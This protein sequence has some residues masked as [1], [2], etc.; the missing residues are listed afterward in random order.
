MTEQELR[1][2]LA[3]SLTDEMPAET[4]M[5]V[6]NKIRERKE[7]I[8][9]SK[10]SVALV[11][12][13]VLTLLSTVAIAYT[14]SREYFED[15]AVLQFESGYYED[16]GLAEKQAMVAILQEHGLISA[17]Q[18]D[19]MTDEAFIDAYMIERYGVEG[20]DRMDTISLYFI[21]RSFY[22]W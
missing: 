1:A 3:R 17:E 10:M 12:A 16:W 22:I 7:P 18:A 21:I 15:V 20:S 19:K 5:A 11:L 14:L 9:R 13:L 2:A 8:V 6:L 4:R